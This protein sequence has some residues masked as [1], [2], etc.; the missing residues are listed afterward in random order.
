[1]GR[2]ILTWSPRNKTRS[3]GADGLPAFAEFT[4]D[5]DDNTSILS[6]EKIN[7]LLNSI[8]CTNTS[9]AVG[10]KDHASFAY[11]KRSWNW[12]NRHDDHALVMVAGTHQCGWNS[13]RIPFN[14]SDIVFDDHT[15]TARMKGRPSEWKDVVDSFELSVGRVAQRQEPHD[16][17]VAPRKRGEHEKHL[18]LDFNHPWDLP[19]H[20]FTSPE[21]SFKVALSCDKCGT[22]GSFDLG[23]Y[24]RTHKKIP[25]AASFTLTPNNVS[26]SITPKL[27]VSG[28]FAEAY[29]KEFDIARIPIYGYSIPGILN[30]GPEVVFSL[31]FSLGPVSGSASISTGLSVGLQNLAE[32]KIELISPR[33]VHSGWTPQLHAEPVEIDAQIEADVDVHARAA[34]QLSAVALGHGFEAGINLRPYLDASLTLAESTTGVCPNDPKHHIFGVN[35]APSVGVSLAAEI[36]NAS[37]GKSL[38][39]MNIANLKEQIPNACFGFGPVVEAKREVPHT[40]HLHGRHQRR[41]RHG[42]N[43]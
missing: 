28:N 32:L 13:H 21:D 22:H 5:T 11:S 34:I 3:I 27:S 14:V 33:V 16:V 30:L 6:L 20:E 29:S 25:Q 26:A 24:L 36:T 2:T 37:D 10:F 39:K 12:V 42:V 8:H 19:E 17:C 41:Y 23:F 15:K 1:M 18:T 43:S 40:P 31:G 4:V 35:L 7:Y 38:A 9:M